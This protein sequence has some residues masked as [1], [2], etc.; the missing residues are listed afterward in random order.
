MMILWRSCEKSK[1]NQSDPSHLRDWAQVKL[2]KRRASW[3]YSLSHVTKA[4]GHLIWSTMTL[5][6]R[7]VKRIEKEE[8]LTIALW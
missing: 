5:I 2:Q 4:E 3:F 6:L 7:V 1:E 8:I